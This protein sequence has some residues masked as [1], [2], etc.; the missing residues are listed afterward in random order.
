LDDP[1]PDGLS[2]EPEDEPL[3]DPSPPSELDGRDVPALFVAV[4]TRAKGLAESSLVPAGRSKVK[5]P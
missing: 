5:L 4:A 3:E 2:D 1:L